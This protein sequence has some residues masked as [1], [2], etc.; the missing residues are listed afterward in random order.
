MSSCQAT[1]TMLPQLHHNLSCS[2]KSQTNTT[3]EPC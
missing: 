2:I 3:T 1:T